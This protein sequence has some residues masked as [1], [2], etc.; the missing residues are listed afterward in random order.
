MILP[1]N[2]YMTHFP[3][4]CKETLKSLYG[5]SACRCFIGHYLLHT[6]N[7]NLNCVA[8]AQQSP[9][10]FAN[11]DSFIRLQRGTSLG[12]KSAALPWPTWQPMQWANQV[13]I[14]PRSNNPQKDSILSWKPT[15]R[16]HLAIIE[17]RVVTSSVRFDAQSDAPPASPL[18]SLLH[19]NPH[20]DSRTES[21]PPH[22]FVSNITQP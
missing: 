11:F 21:F 16:R 20:H 1:T 12:P 15:Y 6:N 14:L 18:P 9:S 3:H 19:P 8:L 4:S 13:L 2:H 17:R 7:V 5:V 10:T 22:I